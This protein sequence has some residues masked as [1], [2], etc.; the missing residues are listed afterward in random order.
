[1]L[2]NIHEE[3]EIPCMVVGIFSGS[4]KP[5]SK[6]AFLRP[7]VTELTNL[8]EHGIIIAGKLIQIRVRAF[9][10]DSPARAFIKG[11]AS[12]NAKAGCLKCT[13]RG[14]SH[15]MV[16]VVYFPYGDAAPRTDE[17]FRNFL[18]GDHQI[19]RTPVYDL[20]QFD[21]IKQVPV[22]DQLHLSDLGVTRKLL[23]IWI[24]GKHR[25]NCTKW[26]NQE[27]VAISSIIKKM[28]LPSEVHRKL[29]GLDH[30]TRWKGSEFANFLRYASPVVLKQFILPTEYNHFM[31]YY[32]AITLFSSNSY[33]EYWQQAGNMLKQF[34]SEFASIYGEVYMSSN[35]HNLLHMYEEVC[36][37]GPLN[38]FSSYPFENKLQSIKK[39]SRHGYKNLQQT[40]NRLLELKH[41]DAASHTVES[42]FP[43]IKTIGND[44]ILNINSEFVLRANDKD[45]WF[46]TKDDFIVKYISC[47]EA[48]STINIYGQHICEIT[49]SY[50]FHS[51]PWMKNIYEAYIY[52]ISPTVSMYSIEDI[53]CKL[54]KIDT[55]FPSLMLYIPLIHTLR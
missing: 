14:Q 30:L 8:T 19:E 49:E 44:I 4:S 39:L 55:N 13:V 31:L 45:A 35:I 54:V 37:F 47:K 28:K 36:H 18:Y 38:T 48:F 41:L 50:T 16:R 46:L 21:L 6:E 17:N 10:A 25:T 27:C 34:V 42:T 40:V 20:P 53:K 15:E 43:N 12:Y 24:F 52:D 9:I 22:S 32:C 23:M 11:T 1:M 26:S 33:R 2:I 5:R 51:S 7:L 3:P 29:R